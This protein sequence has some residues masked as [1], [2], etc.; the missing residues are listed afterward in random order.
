[1]LKIY[2]QLLAL[3]PVLE[4]RLMTGTEQDIYHAAEMVLRSARCLLAIPKLTATF[5]R[6]L[7][8]RLQPA[9]MTLG[10]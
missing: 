7:K 10:L 2:R 3:S 1:M 4:E 6:S 5:F 9:R 8:A